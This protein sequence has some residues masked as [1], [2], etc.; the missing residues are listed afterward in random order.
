MKIVFWIITII[1]FI[2]L[3]FEIDYLI[4]YF[5]IISLLIQWLYTVKF[6]AFSGIDII[7]II[8]PLSLLIKLFFTRRDSIKVRK[9]FTDG[10]VILYYFLLVSLLI[11]GFIPLALG[12]HTRAPLDAV[13]A[14]AKFSSGFIMFFVFSSYITDKQK[15]EKVFFSLP[16]TLL[17]PGIYFF[18]QLITGDMTLIAKRLIPKAGFH[19]PHIITYAIVMILPTVIFKIFLLRD[20]IIRLRWF[21]IFMIMLIITYYSYARTGWLAVTTECMILILLHENKKIKFFII[22]MLLVCLP[23][24]YFLGLLNTALDKLADIYYFF[25]HLDEVWNSNSR[26]ILGLFTGRW[27]IWRADI[28]ELL[29]SNLLEILLGRGIGGANFIAVKAGINA[30]EAHNAYIILLIDFGLINFLL[31]L[32]LIFLMIIRAIRMIRSSDN[33][34]KNI[35]KTWI[36]LI[37]GYSVL[38]MGTHIFYQLVTGVWL[39]WAICGICNGVYINIFLKE[40]Y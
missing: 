38:G 3:F 33:F 19:N 37:F 25:S 6:K 29:H 10:L 39:F 27:G 28:K 20:S 17:L 31:F 7:A 2:L 40:T 13:T 36:V 11:C 35:G 18:W 12:S 4:I 32:F 30:G 5:C 14:W 26:E 15:V 22:A 21:I 9:S 24:F 16:F 1:I 8:L 23:S 34:Y